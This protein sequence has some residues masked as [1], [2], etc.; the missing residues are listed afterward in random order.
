MARK[1][2]QICKYVATISKN[3][4]I[5]KLHDIVNKYNNAFDRTTKINPIDVNSSTYM[6]FP[7]NT[8]QKEYFVI[9]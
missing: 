2:L 5:D 4:F 3:I 9:S 7:K 8:N 6:D 1:Y